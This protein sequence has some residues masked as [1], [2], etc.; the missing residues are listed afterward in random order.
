M[1]LDTRDRAVCSAF[2]SAVFQ[3]YPQ[4]TGILTIDPN[5]SLF[6]D[7]LQTS[8][9]LDLRNRDYFKK[10]LSTNDA[11]TLERCSAG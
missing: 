11:V 10:A 8:R 4:Y 6:C 1:P 2:L 9:T 3:E 7:S 5:G